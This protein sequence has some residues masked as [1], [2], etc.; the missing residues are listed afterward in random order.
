M[1]LAQTAPA[2]PP[3]PPHV[4]RHAATPEDLRAIEQVI[5]DF[6]A[7]KF[8]TKFMERFFEREG[9]KKDATSED[10]FSPNEPIRSP[11]ALHMLP[12]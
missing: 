7:G 3:A 8:D 9:H 12:V 4:G 10:H 11:G 5:A 1:A 2:V 6:Q